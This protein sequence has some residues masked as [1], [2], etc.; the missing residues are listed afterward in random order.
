MTV[1]STTVIST[2]EQIYQS[3]LRILDG[4][5]HQPPPVFDKNRLYDTIP[6]N[7]LTAV[8][9]VWYITALYRLPGTGRTTPLPVTPMETPMTGLL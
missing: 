1:P 2:Y 9:G 6:A 4:C 5:H 8:S 7:T 3:K